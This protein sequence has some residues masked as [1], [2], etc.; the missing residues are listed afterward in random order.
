MCKMTPVCMYMLHNYTNFNVYD[1]TATISAYYRYIRTLIRSVDSKPFS[2]HLYVHFCHTHFLIIEIRTL[3][4]CVEFLAL[5]YFQTLEY[6][7]LP[8]LRL[9]WDNVRQSVQL[10]LP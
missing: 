3:F 5:K 8:G 1:S 10:I 7:P 2:V 6:M 9:G 4:V